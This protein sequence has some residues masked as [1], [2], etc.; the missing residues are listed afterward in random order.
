MS[1][2]AAARGRSAFDYARSLSAVSGASQR[3]RC[4]WTFAFF[5]PTLSAFIGGTVMAMPGALTGGGPDYFAQR[6]FFLDGKYALAKRRPR[7]QT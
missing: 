1:A 4:P 3:R 6:A 2:R 5:V 7:S